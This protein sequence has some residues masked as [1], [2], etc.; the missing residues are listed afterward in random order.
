MTNLL[1]PHRLPTHP[2]LAR[3]LCLPVSYARTALCTRISRWLRSSHIGSII[4]PSKSHLYLVSLFTRGLVL[5]QSQLCHSNQSAVNENQLLS[6][7]V[8]HS[9][10]ALGQRRISSIISNCPVRRHLLLCWALA[11]PCRYILL[12]LVICHLM[13]S[14][15]FMPGAHKHILLPWMLIKSSKYEIS[16]SKKARQ[17]RWC[18]RLAIHD[19]L[20]CS[21]KMENQSLVGQKKKNTT[22]IH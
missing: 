22:T 16:R 17:L 14:F 19:N 13:C 5:P 11:V 3:P 15:F 9:S 21:P 7:R 18:F 20:K 10:T 8:K 1:S 2:G 12:L 6:T 4:H